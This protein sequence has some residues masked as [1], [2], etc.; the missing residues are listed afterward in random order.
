MPNLSRGD[1][2]FKNISNVKWD[3]NAKESSELANVYIDRVVYLIK[4]F[5]E[6]I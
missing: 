1:D 6:K 5:R 3:S 2:T 4:D